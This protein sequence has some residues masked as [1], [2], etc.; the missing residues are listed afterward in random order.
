MLFHSIRSLFYSVL[1]FDKLCLNW[2]K[3]TVDVNLFL[4]ILNIM[5]SLLLTDLFFD[6]QDLIDDRHRYGLVVI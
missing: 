1:I 3:L 4:E 5:R 2:L 6:K